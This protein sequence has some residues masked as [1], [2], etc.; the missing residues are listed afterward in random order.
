MGNPVIRMYEKADEEHKVVATDYFGNEIYPY[1]D[2]IKL[3]DGT[4]IAVDQVD[5]LDFITF[6]MDY[7]GGSVGKIE[8]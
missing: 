2:V 7:C 5:K 8:K 6:L 1:D 3:D 4:L